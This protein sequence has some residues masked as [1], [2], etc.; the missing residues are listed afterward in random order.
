MPR[1]FWMV[2]EIPVSDRGKVSRP[3]LAAEYAARR[4]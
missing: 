4:G 1:D 2:E 3:K